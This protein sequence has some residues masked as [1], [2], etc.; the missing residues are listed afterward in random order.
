MST[1]PIETHDTELTGYVRGMDR[2]VELLENDFRAHMSFLRTA[3]VSLLIAIVS[4]FA[5]IIIILLK[6]Q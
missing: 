5:G 4:G 6:G 1:G 3:F 2:R